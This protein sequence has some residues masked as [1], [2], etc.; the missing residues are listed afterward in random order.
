MLLR[1]AENISQEKIEAHFDALALE[2]FGVQGSGVS[3]ERA[4]ELIDLGVIDQEQIEGLLVGEWRGAPLDPI[5]FMRLIGLPYS[6]ATEQDRALM[7][8]RTLDQWA[9]ALAERA[10]SSIGA[11]PRWEM[12]RPLPEEAPS[13]GSLPEWLSDAEKVG[14]V[15]AYQSAG[16]FI[17]GLGNTLEH[18][19]SQTL[20]ETWKGEELITTPEPA[21]REEQLR[22]IREE[23]GASVLT[24]DTAAETARRMQNRT[25][26][27]ARDF[28]RIAE[29]EL[30]GLHNEGQIY[31][32]AT[33]YGAEARIAR[34]PNSSACSE[35]LALF[36]D[37]EG[38]PRSWDLSEIVGHG[39]NA[40]KKRGEWL[41]TVFP[42]HPLS[43]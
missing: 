8:E 5:L 16:G 1:D 17:R 26:D 2:L 22:A 18:D 27:Y 13:V 33:A 6:R 42:L 29:T 43:L 37:E 12:Q 31:E 19:F 24:K 7:R 36:L 20:Y 3:R 10:P 34:V 35:C 38:S 28:Q 21:K 11:S 40:G 9:Q 41:A 39:T 25:R 14:V 30:Q 4:L 23:L 32:A 15:A